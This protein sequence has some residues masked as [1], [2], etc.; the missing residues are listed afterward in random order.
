VDTVYRLSCT[1]FRPVPEQLT[2]IFDDVYANQPYMVKI[3]AVNSWGKAS[4]PLCAE[5]VT[6]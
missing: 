5:F 1:F 4:E 3:F 6:K 2:V